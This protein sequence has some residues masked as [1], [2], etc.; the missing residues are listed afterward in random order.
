MMQSS[1]NDAKVYALE[2]SPS[3]CLAGRWLRA[4]MYALLEGG[5]LLRSAT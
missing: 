5:N 2:T 1:C 4:Y 3:W